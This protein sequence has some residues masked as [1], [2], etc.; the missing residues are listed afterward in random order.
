MGWLTFLKGSAPAA[1]AS[2]KVALFVDAADGAP[3]YV[4]D[5][6]TVHTLVGAQ[7]EQGPQGDTGEQGPQ[8]PQGVAGPAG[9]AGLNWRG[10]YDGTQSYAEDD[11]VS[12]LNA[13]WFAT[14][15]HAANDGVPP[16]D[17][18][19][20]SAN[21][22]WALLAQEGAQG[23]QGPQG[24][25]GPKGDKGDTGDTG[26]TGPKGDTGDTGATGPAG[27]DGHILTVVDLGSVSGA[28]AID[29]SA[30]HVFTLTLTG[31]VTLSLTGLP[32]AGTLCEAE[33]RLLQDATGGRA[34]TWPANGKWPGGSA[35]VPTADA[36]ALDYVGL[37][38]D[39]AGNWTGYPVEDIG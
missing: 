6:G 9:P 24:I 36:G 3:K 23:P 31:D 11:A 7:G 5:A 33:L 27:A 25:Q 22:G 32:T 10:T 26:A 13:S 37:S 2:G 14:A 39:S 15:A 29:L 20:G 19:G 17:S 18:E 34:V 1:P 38:V 4:D 12:Y 21:T 28:V 30:G 35:F 8:G 16:T